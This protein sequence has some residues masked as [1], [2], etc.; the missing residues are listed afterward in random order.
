MLFCRCGTLSLLSVSDINR[1]LVQTLCK[2]GALRIGLR[3][4]FHS[5]LA[6]ICLQSEQF[7]ITP[8]GNKKTTIQIYNQCADSK[9]KSFH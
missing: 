7:M 5:N 3:S 2:C 8:K 6:Q 4:E 9:R 1:Y